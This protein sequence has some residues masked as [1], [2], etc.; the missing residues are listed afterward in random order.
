MD[1][2]ITGYRKVVFWVGGTMK[3]VCRSVHDN[4]RKRGT[5]GLL[6]AAHLSRQLQRWMSMFP[7]T[8]LYLMYAT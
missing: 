3:R 6:I 5:D 8:L 2:N 1:R 7:S 4:L